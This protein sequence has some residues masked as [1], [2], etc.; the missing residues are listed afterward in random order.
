MHLP[1]V[2]EMNSLIRKDF[3]QKQQYHR[4]IQALWLHMIWQYSFFSKVKSYIYTIRVQKFREYMAKAKI[5]GLQ[6]KLKGILY[7]K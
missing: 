4:A 1:K 3:Y 7:G 2:K 5:V 6:R